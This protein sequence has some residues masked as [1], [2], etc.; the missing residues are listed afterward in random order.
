MSLRIKS[1]RVLIVRVPL[2]FSVEH[3][4]ASRKENIT[5]FLILTA[6]DGSV[7]VGEFLARE[8]VMGETRDEIVEYL[9]RLARRLRSAEIEDPIE[10]IREL[11][12]KAEET[13]GNN[14]AIGALDLA[15]LDVWGKHNRISAAGLLK[16]GA[17]N[18]ERTFVYSGIY[19]FASGVKLAALDFCYVR[20]LGVTDLKVKG[21]GDIERDANYIER[22]RRIFPYRVDIRMDLNGSLA[23]ENA[24]AYFVRMLVLGVRWFEQP[25]AKGDWETSARFQEMFQEDAVLCADEAVCSMGDLE[26]AIR[27]RA[28]GAINIRIGK[29]GGLVAAWEIYQR[30]IGAGLKV[31]LGALV[32]E[33][34]VL[35]FAGLHFAAATEPLAHY[36]GCFG[37]YLVGWDLIEPSLTFSRR[38][39]VS[40][41]RLPNAGLVPAFDLKRLVR[42]AL[43]ATELE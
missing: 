13:P 29:N 17:P 1:F 10:F 20:L 16:S 14:G 37:R 23:P 43:S 12:Q 24:E 6:D 18:R 2:R 7:G 5:G 26:R 9:R 33:T 42:A 27:E 36:E 3:A 34:S 31:Q 39:L 28:F 25:F 38:G 11:W 22:I 19:P 4:L 8:Y 41:Q 21:S 30:A 32:G 15:L 35:A 40:L